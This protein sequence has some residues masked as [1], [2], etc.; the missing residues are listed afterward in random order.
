MQLGLVLHGTAQLIFKN[1]KF[2]AEGQLTGGHIHL[3][4]Q[5]KQISSSFGLS[6][7]V[8]MPSHPGGLQFSTFPVNFLAYLFSH[9]I[10][11]VPRAS[12]YLQL[13]RIFRSSFLSPCQK[14]PNTLNLCE[15]KFYCHQKNFK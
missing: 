11:K 9:S 5:S 1:E 14:L 3:F 15:K 10:S 8:P 12:T 13:R 4:L 2:R 7:E 6:F